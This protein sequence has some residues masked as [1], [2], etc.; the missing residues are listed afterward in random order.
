MDK[1]E[2]ITVNCQYCGDEFTR[3][4]THKWMIVCKKCYKR[5]KDSGEILS[6]SGMCGDK[7]AFEKFERLIKSMKP[8]T[9]K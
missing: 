7:V 2:I 1:Y 4:K 3:V 9:P 8:S 5:W 6:L